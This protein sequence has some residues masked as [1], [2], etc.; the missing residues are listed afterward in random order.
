VLEIEAGDLGQMD[1][2]VLVL[3]QDP[4]KRRCDLASE[5]IPVATWYSSG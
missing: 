5:R 4:P 1:V 2:D 3:A